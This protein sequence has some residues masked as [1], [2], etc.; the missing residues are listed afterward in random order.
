MLIYKEAVLC[1]NNVSITWFATK[2]MCLNYVRYVP[3]DVTTLT[4]EK[5]IRITSLQLT[6]KLPESAFPMNTFK[7]ILVP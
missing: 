7:L 6:R 5:I 1:K 3:S 4:I 2:E